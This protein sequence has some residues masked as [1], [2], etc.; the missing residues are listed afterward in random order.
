MQDFLIYKQ[1]LL[2]FM[3]LFYASDTSVC[4]SKILFFIPV[5]TKCCYLLQQ[6]FL[7][8][9]NEICRPIAIKFVIWVHN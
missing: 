8:T 2:N 4:E 1:L 7:I 9:K 6:I 3:S 5:V